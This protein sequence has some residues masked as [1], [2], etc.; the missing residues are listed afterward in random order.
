M[1]AQLTVQPATLV[2]DLSSRILTTYVA[3]FAV[4]AAGVVFGLR[5]RPRRFG[6][7]A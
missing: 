2:H 5:R 1:P 3:I 4:V 6:A 7:A